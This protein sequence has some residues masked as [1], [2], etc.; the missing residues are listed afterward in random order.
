M[1]KNDFIKN[2]KLQLEFLDKSEKEEILSYYEE[3]IQDAIDNNEGEESFILSLGRIDDLVKTIK[4]DETFIQK[5]KEKRE[6]S[7]I[8]AFG[9]SVRI[10]GYFLYAILFIIVVSVGFSFAVS[11]IAVSVQAIIQYILESSK[12]VSI[13]LMYLGHFTVGVGFLLLGIGLIQWFFDQAK[14]WLNQIMRKVQS[15]QKREGV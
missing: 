5:V 15:W 3:L 2:L 12:P 4:T 1:K 9:V 6:F 14:D 10:I 8:N 7:L 13:Q 11:G